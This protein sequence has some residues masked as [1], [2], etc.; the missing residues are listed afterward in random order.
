[1]VVVTKQPIERFKIR[2]T[3][4]LLDG[5][6][7]LNL[8]KINF[9][10]M[11]VKYCKSENEFH[12]SPLWRG[13]GVGLLKKI[14]TFLVYNILP[15]VQIKD[16]KQVH[17]FSNR[18]S[19]LFLLLLMVVSA[20]A[21]EADS[22]GK[23]PKVAV[24]LS[25]GGAKG[26]AHIGFLK[27]LE[28]GGIHPDI[29]VGTSMGSIVGGYYALGFSPDSIEAMIRHT[30][31]DIVL[32]NKMMLRQVNI[33]EKENLNEY[34]MEF[35]IE[36]WKPKLP[37]GAIQGHEIELMF[38]R[39]AWTAARYKNFD[40]FPIRYRCV[41]VDILTGKPYI[42]KEGDISLAMRSSMSIPTVM[43][44]V[45]YKGMLLVDG[46]LVKNFPVDVA[47]KLG[48]DIVIG[49]YTGGKLLPE[50]ELNSLLSVL[51]QSSLLAGILNAKEQRKMVDIYIEPDLTGLSVSDFSKSDSIIARGYKTASRHLGELKALAKRLN[52]YSRPPAQKA[53]LNDSLYIS[54][55]DVSGIKDKY[56]NRMVLR[57]LKDDHAGWYNFKQIEERCKS[58][59]GTRLFDKVGYRIEPYDSI[60]YK[61]VYRFQEQNKNNLSFAVNYS[62]Y[63]KA[64]IILDLVLR[65]F[66]ISGSKL[67]AKVALSTLP[68]AKIR[69]TK[70][71]GKKSV[72]AL[73]TGYR[74]DES[75]FP[76]YNENSWIKSAEYLR[77]YH[78]IDLQWLLFA[79]RQMEFSLG[80][81][82]VWVNERPL[83][84]SEE[85]LVNKIVFSTRSAS[86]QILYNHLDKKHF[87]NRGI[88]NRFTTTYFINPE[89]QFYFNLDNKKSEYN[90][91]NFLQFRNSFAGYSKFG[92]VNMI[93]EFDIYASLS[94]NA[95][96]LNSFILGGSDVTTDYYSI[97]FWGLPK[98]F[99]VLGSG[100]L[101]RIGF[102]YEFIKNFYITT[103]ANAIFDLY[104]PDDQPDPESTYLDAQ[105]FAG[106]GIG[107]SYNSIIGPIS[108]IVT[109]SINYGPYWTY[110]NIG[111][112]F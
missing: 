7:L 61:I 5:N 82:S 19:I 80:L 106:A 88:Y 72:M 15:V 76:V 24:V 37:S 34:I 10:I 65:N 4:I 1:M 102:R 36:H 41:S 63:S 85:Q 2:F 103:K 74:Y 9:M 87:P 68:K 40:Q 13:V 33:E 8:F 12:Y 48:A 55:F 98:N 67:E 93:N 43:A 94:E 60:Q 31:W 83:V 11:S 47:K 16:F 110:V 108:F 35:P 104:V 84:E 17:S 59:Y 69:F 14:F 75:I 18:I 107:L 26:M 66:Y 22:L 81:N 70:Y 78:H 21:Q 6:L 32:S 42:F 57:Y 25:G 51:K 99:A 58:L 86:F 53:V 90:T 29:I 64:A 52:N 50:D 101:Y 46:G 92:R 95:N 56:T 3:N 91:D 112:R 39:L 71:L 97:P 28:E 38:E 62:N 111:F 23:R 79:S 30:D 100:V 45:K 109:K 20:G 96:Q 89:Y 44:P 73:T 27:V 77:K 49:D 105:A 54:S